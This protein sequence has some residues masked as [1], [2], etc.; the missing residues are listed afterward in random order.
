MSVPECCLERLATSLQ[1][2]L[3]K[4][5]LD[6]QKQLDFGMRPHDEVGDI[7]AM[8]REYSIIP[9]ELSFVQSRFTPCWPAIYNR[10]AMA[11]VWRRL[12]VMDE[13]NPRMRFIYCIISLL[14]Q[15]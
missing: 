12:S 14:T 2:S 6:E 9:S 10:E 5:R 3:P 13:Q 1:L 11:V 4:S 8:A 7:Q 15:I